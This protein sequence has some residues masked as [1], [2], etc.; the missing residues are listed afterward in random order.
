VGRRRRGGFSTSQFVEAL[1]VGAR[2]RNTALGEHGWLQGSADAGRGRRPTRT[3]HRWGG[4]GPAFVKRHPSVPACRHTGASESRSSGTRSCCSM[5]IT[6]RVRLEEQLQISEKNGRPIGLL[7]RRCGAHERE[8]A[9]H[10][11]FRATRTNAAPKTRTANDPRSSRLPRRKD[12]AS[13]L[14]GRPRR[15]QIAPC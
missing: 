9:A 7:A 15:R 5:N 8:H 4:R 6:D 10:R 1:Q 2:G 13:D 11:A 14:S 12:R 3:D